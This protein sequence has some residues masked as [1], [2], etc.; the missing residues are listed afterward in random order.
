MF[1]A[2]PSCC[3]QKNAKKAHFISKNDSPSRRL[4]YSKTSKT[5]N[6]IQARVLTEKFPGEGGNE[7]RPKN[8]SKDQR[9]A[10]LSLFRGMQWKKTSKNSKKTPKIALLCLYLLY[11][12]HV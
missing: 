4:D 7:K 10:L 6:R 11:L 2:D 12:Y 9:I 3:F 1:G 8:S 5:F